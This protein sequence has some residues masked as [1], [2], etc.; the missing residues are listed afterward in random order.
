MSHSLL[1]ASYMH[2]SILDDVLES[3]KKCPLDPFEE[4]PPW[5]VNLEELEKEREARMKE[6]KSESQFTCGCV[7]GYK[8][9]EVK[10]KK[11]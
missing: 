6:L 10:V 4:D 3:M 11:K 8:L 7:N 1:D 2:N 5:R 9:K